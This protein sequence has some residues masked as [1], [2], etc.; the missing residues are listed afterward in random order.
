MTTQ[1]SLASKITITRETLVKA[2]HCN[3]TWRELY[4]AIQTHLRVEITPE[5]ET[6][7][8]LQVKGDSRWQA[9]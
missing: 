1:R 4:V 8:N 7:P 6:Q 2:S 3:K 9:A 5:I